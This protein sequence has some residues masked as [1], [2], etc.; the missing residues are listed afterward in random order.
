MELLSAGQ[1]S[2]LKGI[3]GFQHLKAQ[4]PGHDQHYAALPFG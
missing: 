1:D 4:C 2:V 3:K